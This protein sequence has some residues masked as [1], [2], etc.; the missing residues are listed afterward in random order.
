MKK[1]KNLSK[2]IHTAIV[3]LKINQLNK[4]NKTN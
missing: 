1:S 3:L 4:T 2:A